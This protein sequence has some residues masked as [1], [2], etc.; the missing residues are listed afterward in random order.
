MPN[1]LLIKLNQ[2]DFRVCDV[3]VRPVY[4]IGEKSGIR[5]RKVVPRI[6]WILLKGFIKRLVFKYVIKDFHPLV[7]FYLLGLILFPAGLISGSWLIYYRIFQGPVAATSALFAVFLFV[8]GLQSLFSPC[9]LTWT[10]IK[11]SK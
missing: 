2:H 9:G 10:T 11:T 3:H 5:V 6:S 7:F 8:S 4:N 1:D